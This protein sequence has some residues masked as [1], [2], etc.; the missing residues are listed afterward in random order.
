MKT[1]SPPHFTNPHHVDWFFT[2]KEARLWS[3]FFY[4]IRFIIV[5]MLSS[6]LCRCFL[7]IFY[8]RKTTFCSL[9]YR[10][11]ASHRRVLSDNKQVCVCGDKIERCR[12]YCPHRI[13]KTYI[14]FVSDKR[15]GCNR[16]YL[17]VQI[18]D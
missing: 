17:D 12:T 11:Q 15:V 4:R 10:Q 3:D 1:I 16:T 7:M 18:L 6:I 13:C 14:V 9:S 8:F 2:I 5:D